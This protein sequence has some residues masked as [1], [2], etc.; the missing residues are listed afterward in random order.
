M[1]DAENSF[2]GRYVAFLILPVATAL[3]A[4]IGVK[5]KAWFGVDL[6]TAEIAAWIGSVALG[7]ATWLYNRG[8]YEVAKVTGIDQETVDR[9]VQKVIE[10][11]LPQP[12]T[13]ELT[14]GAG[15]PAT[16]RA[17]GDASLSSPGGTSGGQ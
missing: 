12:P 4:L 8:K 16:P 10:E 9:L 17:P 2:I 6:D 11:K 1:Q 14:P 3:A 5:A 13:G 15:S 7:I